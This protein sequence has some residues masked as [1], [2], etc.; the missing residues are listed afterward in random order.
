MVSR[1]KSAVAF[2]QRLWEQQRDHKMRYNFHLTLPTP[3]TLLLLD[4]NCQHLLFVFKINTGN[5]STVTFYYVKNLSDI[6]TGFSHVI[7]LHILLEN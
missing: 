7:I 1:T 3:L 4:M 5:A 2:V 6:E